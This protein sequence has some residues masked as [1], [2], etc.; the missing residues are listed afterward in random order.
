MALSTESV[1]PLRVAQVVDALATGGKERVAVNLANGLAAA[2]W[3]SYM[4]S[5]R[6]EGPMRAHLSPQVH[7]WCAGRRSR[8]DFKAM[9]RIPAYLAD[10]RIQIVHTHNHSSAYLMS[11]V[12]KF[13]KI[14]PL[15]VVHDHHGPAMDNRMLALSDWL[16]LRHVDAYITVSEELQVRAKRILS[17]SDD[18]CLYIRN[19]VE[20][21]PPSPPYQGPPTV[22]QVANLNWP[23]GHDVS[24]HAA[25]ELRKRFPDLRWVCAGRILEPSDYVAQVK[26]LIRSL[27]MQD[28]FILA[29]EQTD[30]RPL[31]RQA[32]VG[33][34]ASD[35]EGLPMAMLEYMAEQLPVVTTDVGQ[36]P[37]PVR[38]AN[39]GLVV[40]PRQPGQLAEAIAQLLGD[41][42]QARQMAARGRKLL[43]TK[44]SVEV[45]VDRV[46]RLY[47]DLLDGRRGVR[48]GAED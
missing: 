21:F 1:E 47:M 32:D 25:A 37:E 29:G 16:M 19:G 28:C 11:L 26:G 13:S 2:G 12:L 22:V 30:V 7:S 10:N 4:L 45:M 48:A 5:T 34:I 40:P 8:F 14:R 38:E 6:S 24:V 15:H 44:F 33:V 27:G 9:T 43:E 42:A 18:R 17:M 36:C 41:P 23:K 31:L 39:C 3:Q 20:V 35:S 46:R